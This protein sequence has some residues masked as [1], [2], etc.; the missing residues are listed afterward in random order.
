MSKILAQ[1]KT[2]DKTCPSVSYEIECFFDDMQ[3]LL[4][5]QINSKAQ[6]IDPRLNEYLVM[7]AENGMALTFSF[8]SVSLSGTLLPDSVMVY[9]QR[10][11]FKAHRQQS[12]TAN[13]AD[14]N[15]YYL[16]AHYSY[17]SDQFEGVISKKVGYRIHAVTF[18]LEKIDSII[19]ESHANG[20]HYMLIDYDGKMLYHH[21][22][23]K[24]VRNLRD[25][26]GAES[27]FMVLL[28]G[29]P[30]KINPI[31]FSFRGNDYTGYLKPMKAYYQDT[32][33]LYYILSYSNANQPIILESAATGNAVVLVS[34]NIVMVVFMALLMAAGTYR[35]QQLSFSKFSY[36]WFRPSIRNYNQLRVL[37]RYLFFQCGF[38]ILLSLIFYTDIF[39]IFLIN[40]ESIVFIALYRYLLLNKGR[41]LSHEFNYLFVVGSATLLAL[42]WIIIF[43][44]S[45]RTEQLFYI[46]FVVVA[47]FLRFMIIRRRYI[48]NVHKDNISVPMAVRQFNRSLLLWVATVAFLPTIIIYNASLNLE[49]SVWEELAKPAEES[50][51]NESDS[52]EQSKRHD[53][54]EL[55]RLLPNFME[56][57]D[58]RVISHRYQYVDPDILQ[59]SLDDDWKLKPSWQPWGFTMGSFIFLIVLYYLIKGVITR[60][61]FVTMVQVKSE[62]E[63]KDLE[64]YF[65]PDGE[66]NSTRLFV[67]GLPFSGRTSKM[68]SWINH[69]SDNPVIFDMATKYHLKDLEK[70]CLEHNKQGTQNA[71]VAGNNNVHD[72]NVQEGEIPPATTAC[73]II[74]NFNTLM[75]DLD[76][77]ASFL[78]SLEYLVSFDSNKIIIYSNSAANEIIEMLGDNKTLLSHY[79]KDRNMDIEV[80]IDKIEY[81][82]ASFSTLLF[83]LSGRKD[84]EL[85]KY[86]AREIKYT[87]DIQLVTKYA[88]EMETLVYD[89]KNENK[90]TKYINKLPFIETVSIQNNAFEQYINQIQSFNK[91][92]YLALWNSLTLRE[93]HVVYDLADNGF[94]NYTNKEKINRLIRKGLVK[95]S[96][97]ANRIRL[98]NLSFNNFVLTIISKKEVDGFKRIVRKEGN[99]QSVRILLAAVI[100]GILVFIYF[101]DPT[102]MSKTVG[103]LGSVLAVMGLI[104]RTYMQISTG[105]LFSKKKDGESS[106]SS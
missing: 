104:A 49:I 62:L 61:Y 102:F 42:L 46:G 103:V 92:Y 48:N 80:Y 72:S 31:N 67:V 87:G 29:N 96:D 43:Y 73:I 45:F 5:K 20:I 36:D 71:E 78:E 21:E 105:S 18:P 82:L 60:I 37:N 35:S 63:G 40:L 56:V 75:L 26:L 106:P 25:E 100:L 47:I 86:M 34:A 91:G 11:Y 89:K 55:I 24:R 76:R 83:R 98:L 41:V 99:W 68:T 66:L 15:N 9:N 38:L 14:K 94:A 1:L 84:I 58:E 64:D 51:S 6:V 85:S 19:E 77:L 32:K 69:Q 10:H 93:K 33:H 52:R 70:Y 101:A 23:I 90:R 53:F 17:A 3:F 59:S 16:G 12:Q 81:L 57:D 27:R 97:K 74:K 2:E 28:S 13:P 50:R 7:D 88:R 65:E 79:S 8:D 54:Y 4:D 95:V 22:D 44:Y 30:D 39:F